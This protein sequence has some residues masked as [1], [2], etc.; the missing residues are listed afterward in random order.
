MSM[1]QKMLMIQPCDRWLGILD[2]G[3]AMFSQ[4]TQH[5]CLSAGGQC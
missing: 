4:K 3:M 1:P 2:E 5:T